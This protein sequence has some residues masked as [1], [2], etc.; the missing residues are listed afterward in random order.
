MNIRRA[1]L[2]DAP[3]IAEFNTRL[4]WE[5][6]RRRLAPKIIGRGV[7]AVL[8]DETKGSYFVAERDDQVIGQLLITREWS[9]WRAGEFWWLQSVYVAP[10]F[11]GNGVFTA[12][13]QQVTRL[14]EQRRDV[15]GL[16]LYVERHNRRA[17]R[18]YQRLGLEPTPYQIY[19]TTLRGNTKLARP[20]TRAKL[21]A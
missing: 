19:E 21:R 12:L 1:R 20:K 4:A 15:C 14:A 6:E 9:D 2:A 10:E 5:T 8:R 3:L 13:F 17:Q 16:R 11:R 18:S 7:R